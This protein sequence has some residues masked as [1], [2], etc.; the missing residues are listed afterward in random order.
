LT[1]EQIIL[2]KRSWRI[3]R[4]ISPAVVGDLFYSKLFADNPALRKM[5][6]GD[7]QQQYQKLI[8]MLNAVVSRLDKPDELTEEIA[9]MAHRHAD[10]GVRP[11]HYKLVG[12]ALLWTLQKGMGRDWNDD[13][14]N[15]W[16]TCYNLLAGTMISSVAAAAKPGRM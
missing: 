16:A 8:D 4:G 1:N 13:V 7:M 3:F 12:T 5:F 10:Y 14:K 6:P 2:V 9:A 11:A 15:A